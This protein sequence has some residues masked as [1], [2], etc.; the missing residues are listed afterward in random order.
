M[1]LT[2]GVDFPESST[3]C[4]R[5]E[6]YFRL[7]DV[8]PVEHSKKF[9]WEYCKDFKEK[10]DLASI[11]EV[12]IRSVNKPRKEEN[13][14]SKRELGRSKHKDE[15]EIGQ[16]DA[17]QRSLHDFILRRKTTPKT[18][19]RPIRLKKRKPKIVKRNL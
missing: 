5:C 15:V 6:L 4:R 12:N 2:E 10:I 7:G 8:C 18:K 9:Y 14:S 1:Q 19:N 16:T 11:G 17:G 3:D 13:V